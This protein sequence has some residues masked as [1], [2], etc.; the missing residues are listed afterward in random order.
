MPGYFEADTVV[1]C[2]GSL[3]GT[4]A[5]AVSL[6]DIATGW[7]AQRAVLGKGET[8]VLEAIADIESDL[9]FKILGFDSDNGNEFINRHLL[10]YLTKRKNPV[11]FTRSRPYKKNDN[12]HI[13]QKNWTIVRQ[14]MG[15]NRIE[16]HEAIK[17]MNKLYRNEFSMFLNYFIPSVKLIS[18]NRKGSK[19]IRRHDKAKT[20]YQRTQE[21]KFVDSK[22][23]ERLKK[24]KARLNPFDLEK[25]IQHQIKE[26]QNLSV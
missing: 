26:I 8:G 5:Y 24:T 22:I 9:P 7:T 1:H 6:V 3:S 19:Q 11:S 4:M 20:P 14:Y 15:Y 18:K 16:T 21:S 12:A 25:R 2:G 13:E 17:L 23:K 10:K